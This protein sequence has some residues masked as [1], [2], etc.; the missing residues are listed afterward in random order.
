MAPEGEIERL[1]K[2]VGDPLVAV[3]R[4]RECGSKVD[5]AL[6]L[7]HTV[8]AVLTWLMEEVRADPQFAG[9]RPAEI[10]DYSST[11]LQRVREYV[12]EAMGGSDEGSGSAAG[13]ASRPS[14]TSHA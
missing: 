1:V 9:K 14:N 3:F 10:L 11:V 7:E 8:K 2:G 6:L 4:A 13:R 12:W 5:A